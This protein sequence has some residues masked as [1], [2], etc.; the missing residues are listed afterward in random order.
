MFCWSSWQKMGESKEMDCIKGIL[1][2]IWKNVWLCRALTSRRSSN[3]RWSISRTGIRLSWKL[4]CTINSFSKKPI[5]SIYNWIIS[6]KRKGDVTNLGLDID[7]ARFNNNKR[8]QWNTYN[9]PALIITRKMLC[10]WDSCLRR[11]VRCHG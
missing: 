6:K 8:W 10:D 5:Q 11:L 7:F 4:W 2:K 1:K 9:H 3:I